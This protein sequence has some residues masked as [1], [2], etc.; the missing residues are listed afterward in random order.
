MIASF[1]ARRT[2]I[3]GCASWNVPISRASHW[4]AKVAVEQ[5]LSDALFDELDLVAD[6]RLGHAEIL[7]GPGEAA[8]PGGRLEDP[9][10]IQRELLR[11]LHG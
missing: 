7:P 10:R 1:A 2:A 11:H 3:F 4:E 9:Q 6:R 5:R 8:E